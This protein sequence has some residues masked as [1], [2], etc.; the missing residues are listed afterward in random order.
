MKLGQQVQCTGY[1]RK[2][3]NHYIVIEPRES[4]DG[5][6]HC[7]FSDGDIDHI[8][9][10][11][12]GEEVLDWEDDCDRYEVADCDFKGVYVGTKQVSTRLKAEFCQDEY[13]IDDFGYTSEHDYWRITKAEPKKYAIVY[14]ASGKK[15]LV[16]LDR[17]RE[18]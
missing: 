6:W 5:C 3:P 7:Y 10:D 12:P 17:M 16:P 8:L 15:R 14:Y 2:I 9:D 13:V 11:N 4:K 1:I 18:L